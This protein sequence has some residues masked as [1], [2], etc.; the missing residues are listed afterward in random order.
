M[1]GEANEEAASG[2]LFLELSRDS[3]FKNAVGNF[4]L[5]CGILQGALG[6]NNSGSDN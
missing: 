4:R 3:P 1:L 5:F 2:P 6:F